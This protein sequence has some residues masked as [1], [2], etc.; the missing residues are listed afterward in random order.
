MR[1]RLTIWL[2]AALFMLSG[3][4]S[5]PPPDRA[6]ARPN[7]AISVPFVAQE[8]Y[9]CGPAALAMML[10]WADRPAKATELVDEVWLPKRQGSLGMELRGASRA[11]DLL[12]YPVRTP[13]ALF[14]ELQAGNPVLVMQ[15]L[16]LPAWPQW[17]FAVVTGYRDS[18]QKMILHSGTRQS[19]SS[20]WNR[21]IRTWARADLWGFTLIQPGQ[22]PASATPETLFKAI[23]PMPNGDAF[24]SSAVDAFPKNGPLRFGLANAQW[25][26]GQHS[27]ALANFTRAT[28]LA[29]DFAPAWNNL[30]YAQHHDGRPQAARQSLCKARQLAPQDSDIQAS[31]N[32]LLGATCNLGECCP[33]EQPVSVDSAR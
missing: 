27:Q 22:L 7:T 12:P 2:A 18:G 16:A 9:Q 11:R 31:M 3:C 14:T 30:A 24:W 8:K 15:N 4:Q 23:T 17:H 32:E 33:D 28:E 26:Q 13:E 20:R 1:Q 6:S 21:F 29:P 5:V 25:S 19:Q 10:Q